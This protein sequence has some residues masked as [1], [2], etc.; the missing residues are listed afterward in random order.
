MS[1]SDTFVRVLRQETSDRVKGGTL[2]SGLRRYVILARACGAALEDHQNVFRRTPVSHDIVLSVA[3]SA[4]LHNVSELSLLTL[5]SFHCLLRPA[6]AK[7]IRWCDMNILD[8]ARSTRCEKV[9]G[10]VHIRE[11]KTR[12]VTAHAAQFTDATAQSGGSLPL[13]T[14]PISSD[15]SATL[16]CHISITR[17]ILTQLH[18]RGRWTSERTLERYI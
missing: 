3:V 18:R 1:A 11:P 9:Y 15:S 7:Q 5:L 6:E 16:A 2:I 4:W 13:S 8:G 10:A 14:M 12:R 17:Y